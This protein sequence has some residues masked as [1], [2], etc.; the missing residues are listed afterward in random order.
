MTAAQLVNLILER[1]RT[2]RVIFKSIWE[3]G[4]LA[5]IFIEFEYGFVRYKL[6]YQN[7]QIQVARFLSDRYTMTDSYSQWVEG[8]LNRKTRDDE[9]KLS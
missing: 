5:P 2:G 4:L 3:N 1:L 7:E 9:G 8:V 6:T